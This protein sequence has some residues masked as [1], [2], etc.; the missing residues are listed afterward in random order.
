MHTLR[1]PDDRFVDLPDFDF[2]PHYVEVPDGAGGRG[3]VEGWQTG[4]PP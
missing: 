4:Q 3:Q 2:A 1:T